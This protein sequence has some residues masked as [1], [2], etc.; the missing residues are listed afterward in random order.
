MQIEVEIDDKC[1]L[2]KNLGKKQQVLL[3]HGDSIDKVA[4]NYKVIAT[5]KSGIVAGIANEKSHIFGLQFHPEVDLT[6][7]GKEIF[8]NFLFD[9][10]GLSGTFTLHD[11]ES[12]CLSYIRDHVGENDKVLMLLS[13]KKK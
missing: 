3:T 12:K 4:E 8:K 13:G 7:N 11:R 10:C 5:S 6:L 2:F 1:T 9:I